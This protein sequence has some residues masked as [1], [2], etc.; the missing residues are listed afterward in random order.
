LALR[1]GS[2]GDG[3]KTLGLVSSREKVTIRTM[4]RKSVVRLISDRRN[5]LPT[6]KKEGFEWVHAFA[7]MQ[8]TYRNMDAVKDGILSSAPKQ[9]GRRSKKK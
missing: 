4:M 9:G 6:P 1:E 7:L 5:L 3:G 2:G 8:H